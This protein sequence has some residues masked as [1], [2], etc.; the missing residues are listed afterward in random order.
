[1]LPTWKPFKTTGEERHLAVIMKGLFKDLQQYSGRR[2]VGFQRLVSSI[3]THH[4]KLLT[5]SE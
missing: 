2:V 5:P 3:P 4:K 1:M